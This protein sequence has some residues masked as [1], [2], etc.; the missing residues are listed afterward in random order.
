LIRSF[1]KDVEEEVVVNPIL[2][3]D[4]KLS[5]PEDGEA[6]DPRLYEDLGGFADIKE[7]MNKILEDYNF[8]NSKQMNLVLFDDALDHI[9][10]IHRILRFNKGSGLLV[11][12]GG[13]GKQSLTRLSTYLACYDMWQ[14]TLKR[15]YREED[16]RE[17]LRELFK[18]VLKGK[19]KTF[20]FT[21]A[22]VVDEGFLEL[23]NNILTIGMV[24]ALFAE[25]EKDGLRAMVDQEIQKRKL[26]TTSEFAWEYFINKARD[27]LHIM[28]CMSP[29]GNSLRIRCRNFP[30]LITN[31]TIDW[32]FPWPKDALMDVAKHFIGEVDLSDDQREKVCEHLVLCHQSVQQYSEEFFNKF[33]RKNYSTPKNYLDFI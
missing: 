32:F 30:G 23:I 29:A 11:G 12:Y 6:E 2:F 9:T 7:K 22:H 14:I 16:F 24:P 13:S 21:D 10:K 5:D 3:G 28:L 27:N 26:P 1:F 8:S 20:M 19:P 18:V 15:G 33:K 4:F 25:D 31:T 17:E